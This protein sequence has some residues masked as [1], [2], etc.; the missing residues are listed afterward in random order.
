MM[1]MLKCVINVRNNLLMLS[2]EKSCFVV[3]CVF[4]VILSK[5][6]IW[7]VTSVPLCH[8][9]H[10]CHESQVSGEGQVS[11]DVCSGQLGA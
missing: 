4:L 2:W 11:R 5:P 9:L 1:V 8:A 3:F 7:L 10:C 6:E